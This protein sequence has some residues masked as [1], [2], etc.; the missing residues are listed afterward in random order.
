[1]RK[2]RTWLM[3]VLAFAFIAPIAFFA[4]GCFLDDPPRDQSHTVM[5]DTQGGTPVVNVDFTGKS[6]WALNWELDEPEAPTR[7][8]HVFIGWFYHATQ[9]SQWDIDPIS[10][11]HVV[12]NA[13][14]EHGT[15]TL[16]ARWTPY[17]T[18]TF[19]THG[20]SAVS[21]ARVRPGVDSMNAPVDPT[22]QYFVFDG[23]F[24]AATGGA[25]FDFT[26][27]TGDATAHAQWT[28]YHRIT[29]DMQGVGTMADLRVRP[30]NNASAPA[31]PTNALYNFV[32]WF[33]CD[34]FL[35]PFNFSNPITGDITIYAKWDMKNAF[36]VFGGRWNA[37]SGSI[38]SI[39][40]GMPGGHGNSDTTTP[41]SDITE[42]FI[43]IMENNHFVIGDGTGTMHFWFNTLTPP[44]T[45]GGF[46]S[47]FRWSMD[48]M[49]EINFFMASGAHDNN[50]SNNPPMFT[51]SIEILACGSLQIQVTFVND[52]VPPMVMTTITTWIF[53]KATV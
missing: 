8:L 36:E 16:F 13:A 11:P 28:P 12:M 50:W 15:S 6:V 4:T 41:M 21:N 49:E 34:E 35:T 46:G 30:G 51:R 29:L 48:N 43:T 20:G 9:Q 24:T 38:R 18:V 40:T 31:A 2:T 32:N 33:T 5:F 39:T 7:A 19:N 22:R 10:F 1:M 53:E 25:E 3:S 27:I 14:T 42:N 47:N 45:F 37:V 23:W 52:M 44:Q 26:N 17:H